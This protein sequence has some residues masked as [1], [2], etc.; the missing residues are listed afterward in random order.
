MIIGLL[1]MQWTV[2]LFLLTISHGRSCTIYRFCFVCSVVFVSF[3]SISM[4]SV[5]L[6]KFLCVKCFIFL[7]AFQS[8]APH[9]NRF[10]I[11]ADISD[12]EFTNHEIEAWRWSWERINESQDESRSF[13]S[14][15]SVRKSEFLVLVCPDYLCPSELQNSHL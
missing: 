8:T 10:L 5:F 7:F 13:C 1:F 4:R 9:A 6:R 11:H 3:L 12:I 15:L 14:K 2:R